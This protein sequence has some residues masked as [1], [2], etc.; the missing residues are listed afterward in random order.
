MKKL[1]FLFAALAV[2]AALPAARRVIG[3]EPPPGAI[4][5]APADV[6]QT[7]VAVEYEG[8]KMWLPGTVFAKVG[9]SVRLTLINNIPSEPNT[10]GYAIDELGIKTVVARG[11]QEVVEFKA[12]KAG[13]FRGYCQ[14]HPR[15]VGGQVV[16][17]P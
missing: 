2:L 9:Q 13:I 11:R 16:V 4:K 5:Q 3:A 10:H 15:H 12:E 14:L 8:T 1:A 17:L 6:E 7:L